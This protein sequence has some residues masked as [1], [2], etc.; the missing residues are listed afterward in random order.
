MTVH[1]PKTERYEG[2]DKRPVPIVPKLLTILQDAYDA[3]E[4]GVERVC[5]LSRNNLHREGRKVLQADGVDPWHSLF[6]TLRQRCDTELKQHFPAYVVDSWLGQCGDVSKKHYLMIPADVW[7][8]A[9]SE[10]AAVSS[11]IESQRVAKR[12][13]DTTTT[14]RE[15]TVT[16][17]FSAEN[18]TS[19]A[20]DRTGDLGFMNPTL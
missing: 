9:A 20:R 19:G 15:K 2:K 12:P 14:P 10:G 17:G 7:G 11:R 1:S 13:G 5:G 6:K 3:A 18:R 8:R 16:I 4:T